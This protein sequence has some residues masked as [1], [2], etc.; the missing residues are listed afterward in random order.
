MYDHDG[1]TDQWPGTQQLTILVTFAVSLGDI[2]L[3]CRLDKHSCSLN[4]RYSL[5][6]G[7]L[8]AVDLAPLRRVD[9]NKMPQIL[10]TCL[11]RRVPG[12]GQ[13]VHHKPI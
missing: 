13:T 5:P 1:A 3:C 6:K 11:P 2:G 9:P 4:A 12:N 10:I 7:R 8:T